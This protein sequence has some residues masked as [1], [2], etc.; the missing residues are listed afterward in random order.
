MT[1]KEKTILQRLIKAAEP[2]GRDQN[3]NG[4]ELVMEVSGTIPYMDE[5]QEAID[6]AKEVL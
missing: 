3:Q 2:F 1:D 4:G 5:L 6:E